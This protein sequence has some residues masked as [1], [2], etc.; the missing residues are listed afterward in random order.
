MTTIH[1]PKHKDFPKGV[2]LLQNPRLNKGTAFTKVERFDFGLCG[3]L[4]DTVLT[5]EEQSRRV[6]H[7]YCQQTNDLE[8]Y[9]FLKNLSARNVTLFY[10]VLQKHLEEMMPII[11]TPT[12][13][14]ACQKYSVIYRQPRGLYLSDFT[15]GRF[16]SLL[17]NWDEEDIRIIVVTDGERILGLGDLGA[18]G[19]G[20]PEGKLSLY[21]VCAGINPDMCLPITLDTGTNNQDLL[22]DPLYVGQHHERVRGK[23]YDEM[24]EEF[25]SA[26]A[27]VFPN[28]IIQFEDFGNVNAFRLLERY[29]DRACT[30]NDDIQGTASVVLAG[31]FSALRITKSSLKDQRFLFLGA[32]EAGIGIGQLISSALVLEGMSPEEARRHCWY[33]DSRGLVVSSRTNLEDRKLEFAHDHPHIATLEEAVKILKPTALIGV[34]GIPSS[35]SQEAVEMM[36]EI[37]ER[38]IIFALSNPTSKAE[39]TAENAYKWSNGRCVFASGSPFDAVTHNGKT[40]VPGQGNNAYIFPGV[41]LGVISSHAKRVTDQMFLVAAKTLAS[42]VEESDLELGRVYPPLGDI[43][44][45]SRSIAIEVA[46]EAFDQGLTDKE[47]PDDLTSLIERNM[48]DPI[49]PNYA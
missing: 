12:V 21:T 43:R 49:Y 22:N 14:L 45:V 27:E 15:R 2:H 19:M 4:P 37:N 42:L 46:R 17:R 26:V 18:N 20:I 29:K 48:W 28:A 36:T 10:Y 9:V 7:N 23:V 34:S 30:F 13:G 6:Y 38:P 11:Y 8:K 5:Q 41:G 3:L 31:I 1:D 44:T 25:F 39:C 35:F 32:G 33:M 40:Y 16:K 24:V 47:R